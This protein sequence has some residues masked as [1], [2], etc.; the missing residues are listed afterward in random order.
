MV[1]IISDDTYFSLGAEAILVA[2]GYKVRIKRVDSVFEPYTPASENDTE[3][4]LMAIAN[5]KLAIATL[6]IMKMFQLA[7]V[8]FISVSDK[9]LHSLTYVSGVARKN[10]PC[11]L[12]ISVLPIVKDREISHTAQKFTRREAEVMNLL[13]NGIS[14]NHIANTL[15]I[16]PKTVSSY[17]C[18]ALKKA[19]MKRT[20]SYAVLAYKKYQH[21]TA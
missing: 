16:K 3:I 19:G 9:E 10:I 12:L 17:K 11:H 20:N 8:S 7:T 2:A 4:V 1:T 6:S 14:I 13:V 21:I 5:K 15:S 18:S